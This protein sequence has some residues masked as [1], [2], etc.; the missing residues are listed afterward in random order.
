MPGH[1]AAPSAGPAHFIGLDFPRSVY[2][3]LCGGGAWTHQYKAGE[4]HRNS[5]RQVKSTSASCQETF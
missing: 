3:A 4:L 1:P 2:L 5:R